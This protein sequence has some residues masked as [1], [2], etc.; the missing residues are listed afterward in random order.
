MQ[1][2]IVSI[3]N[4]LKINFRKK[5]MTPIKIAKKIKIPDLVN[6]NINQQAFVSKI[7]KPINL[8]K[9]LV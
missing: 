8:L 9:F 7:K 4:L 2:V 5:M 1:I 6:V 3:E